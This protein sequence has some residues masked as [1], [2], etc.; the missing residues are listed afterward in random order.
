VCA[1]GVFFR[2][3]LVDCLSWSWINGCLFFI[4]VSWGGWEL[5]GLEVE[6]EVVCVG[7][8]AGGGTLF[9]TSK[10]NFAG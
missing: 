2:K 3:R 10:C 6:E 4:C 1:G 7:R 5:R 9:I 8:G